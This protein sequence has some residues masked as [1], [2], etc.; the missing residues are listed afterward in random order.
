MSEQSP[1][2]QSQ[3]PIRS[4]EGKPPAL[5]TNFNNNKS[6]FNYFVTNELSA[7]SPVFL[8]NHSSSDQ[9]K[10]AKKF[11]FSSEIV[12]FMVQ[13]EKINKNQ[14]NRGLEQ[15]L[16]DDCSCSPLLYMRSFSNGNNGNN[17]EQASPE[18]VE[19]QRKPE[20]KNGERLPNVITKNIIENIINNG[21]NL[22]NNG[23]LNNFYVYYVKRL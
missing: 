3:T 15:F 12:D 21:T 22:I 5:V 7:L 17:F 16:G 20:K 13:P 4:R 2:P 18:F 10:T 6:P 19:D 1:N 8:R 11:S 23:K 9:Q 14:E